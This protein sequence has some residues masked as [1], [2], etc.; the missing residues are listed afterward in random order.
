MSSGTTLRTDIHFSHETYDERW[1]VEED[2]EQAKDLREAL[3]WDLVRKNTSLDG[4]ELK[5]LKDRLQE[6]CVEIW[7][8]EKLLLDWDD[9]ARDE[10]G[11]F[12]SPILPNLDFS[13]MLWGD[14]INTKLED[15]K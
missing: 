11:N 9:L 1:K 13:P 12:K 10:E 14:F 6:T 3:I 5:E 7:K 15:L 2:L 8:F 4:F